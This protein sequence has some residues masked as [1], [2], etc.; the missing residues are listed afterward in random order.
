MTV[1]MKLKVFSLL[2]AAVSIGGEGG[3]GYCYQFII[4]LLGKGGG[5]F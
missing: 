5:G 4:R 1:T 3:G 2:C